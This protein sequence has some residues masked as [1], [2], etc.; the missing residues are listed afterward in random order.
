MEDI[1]DGF[2]TKA[3]RQEL[4][5]KNRRKFG[6]VIAAPLSKLKF[7]RDMAAQVKRVPSLLDELFKLKMGLGLQL[8]AG[9]SSSSTTSVS[10]RTPSPCLPP[11]YEVGRNEEKEKILESVLCYDSRE[12][13][14]NY[15]SFTSI[16][17]YKFF[18]SFTSS[19]GVR[20]AGS[21]HLKESADMFGC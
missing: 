12:S 3:A 20:L 17:H 1:L 8:A 13:D 21:P 14:S 11:E 9:A 15:Q 5:A 18:K 6:G 4:K 10:Q 7:N 16:Q 2:G 19:L